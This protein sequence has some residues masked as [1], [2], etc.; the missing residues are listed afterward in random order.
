MVVIFW[1][2]VFGQ[3]ATVNAGAGK[4]ELS[5][6]RRAKAGGVNAELDDPKSITAPLYR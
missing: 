2:F 4:S 3:D 1:W 5:S 6:A